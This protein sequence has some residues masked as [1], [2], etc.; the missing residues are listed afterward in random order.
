MFSFKSTI[1]FFNDLFTISDDLTKILDN[2][3]LA[4][5]KALMTMNE[6]LPSCV[7]IPFTKSTYL[8]S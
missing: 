1:N 5:K 8:L 2:K 3:K 6:K 4:L 7:Y